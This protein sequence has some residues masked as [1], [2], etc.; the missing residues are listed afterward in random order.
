MNEI[1]YD[2]RWSDK[3]DDTF[4]QDFLDTANQVF[5][6]GFSKKLFQRKYIDNIYGTSVLAVVYLDGV[7]VA[8][9]GLWRNDLNGTVAYQPGDTCV[10]D[11]CRGKGIFTE[12]TK[13]SMAMIPEDAW[14]YNFPNQNSYPG[15]RKMG[16]NLVKEYGFVLF[17]GAKGFLREHPIKVDQAYADWWLQGHET[18]RSFQSG[19]VYF[20]AKP[21]RKYCYQVL[22]ATEKEVAEQ[23][24]K[25][26]AGICFYRSEKK[27]FYNKK[28]GLPL[29][30][31]S[32]EKMEYIPIWKI[33][34]L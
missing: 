15:Y 11:V 34:V 29:H 13:R 25:L 28:L 32:R 3:L 4:I 7:P 10:L 30:V 16:W 33:D 8:A 24:P 18:M 2:C 21:M 26:H 12:M 17:I 20:L 5:G 23:F 1:V 31:V 9:R 14:V 22:A 27:T 19:G 6:G